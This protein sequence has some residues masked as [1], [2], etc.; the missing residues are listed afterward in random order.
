MAKM[1]KSIFNVFGF[2]PWEFGQQNFVQNKCA[3]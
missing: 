2:C 3:K 1:Y